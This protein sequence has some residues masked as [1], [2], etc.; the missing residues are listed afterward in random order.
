M[1]SCARAHVWLL[2]NEYA[3]AMAN[4]AGAIRLCPELNLAAN[5]RVYAVFEMAQNLISEIRF[6]HLQDKFLDLCF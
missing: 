2:R 6:W 1:Y 5:L 3:V 4:I